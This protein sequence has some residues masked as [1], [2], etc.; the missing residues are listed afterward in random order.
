[1]YVNRLFRTTLTGLGQTSSSSTSVQVDST[2]VLNL[3]DQLRAAQSRLNNL[4]A[5]MQADSSLAAAIGRD[6]TSQQAALGDLISKYVG[7][8]TAIFGQAPVG[9]GNPL[10]IAGA[11]AVI[12][13]YITAQIYLWHQKQDVLE[14]QA[15]AQV[16]AEQNRSSMLD[17]A[18]QAQ[19]ALSTATAAGDTAGAA[20]AQQ[21]LTTILGQIGTPGTAAGSA[22]PPPP[23]PS[24]FSA[25]LSANWLP[26]AAIGA[27]VFILPGVMGKR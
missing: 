10:L 25:W 20:A 27:A 1:V 15:Q 8:Y 12:L 7:V 3:G 21:T 19:D 13:A 9:L 2:D 18:Q 23:P 17:M 6:V 26:V 24:T 4:F 16:L 22:A 11:V 5:Q 14:Q